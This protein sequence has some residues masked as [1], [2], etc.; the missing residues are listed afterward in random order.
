MKMMGVIFSNIYDKSLGALTTVRAASSIPFGGRYRLIDFILSNMVNSDI[1]TIGIIAKYNYSSLMDHLHYANDWDLER[2]DGGL[3]ILPPFGTGKAPIYSGKLD[4]LS[5][6]LDYLNKTKQEYVVISDSTVVCNIDFNE[7][8]KS[9]IASGCEIT[10]VAH[11]EYNYPGKTDIIFEADCD[12]N[13]SE[14]LVDAVPED[15][16]LCGMGM[17]IMKRTDLIDIVEYSVS[18][19]Y[20]R[21]E[22][23]FLQRCFYSDKI[24]ANVYEFRKTILR[25]NSIPGYLEN[26]MKLLSYDVRKEIFLEERPIFTKVRNEPPTIY[27]AGCQVRNSMIADGC[28]IK[29]MVENSIIFRDVIIEPGAIV[30]N[31]VIMQG[32]KIKSGAYL[33]YAILD[34]DVVING[35]KHMQGDSK[36]PVIIDKGMTI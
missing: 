20:T 25:N 30:K 21:F 35:D 32:T 10:C 13:V 19:G 11:R 34:K 12:G 17:Y 24:T 36:A 28:E 9:H 18:R 16:A 27:S 14:I 8:L 29:G 7:V 4:A 26:N 2:K 23:D 31:S 5:S 33:N 1:T 15:G 22:A 3:Y 6:A